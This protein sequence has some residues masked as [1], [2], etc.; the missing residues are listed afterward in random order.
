MCY[1]CGEAIAPGTRFGFGEVC[2]VC[3]KDQHICLQ[4]SFYL[5]G[6]HWDCRESV[7]A[8]VFDKERRNFCEWFV[9]DPKFSK[10]DPS[11]KDGRTDA[12]KAKNSFS[13]L[14]G[15]G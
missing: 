15:D 9:P 10:K 2:A 11:R 6:A 4:C 7:D 8:P 3:G 14:F 5:P 13:S 1:F 12:A